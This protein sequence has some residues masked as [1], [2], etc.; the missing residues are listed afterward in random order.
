ML[1]LGGPKDISAAWR[2]PM[3]RRQFITFFG[4]AVALWPLPTRAQVQPSNEAIWQQFTEWLPGA[5]PVDGPTELFNQYRSRLIANGASAAEAD[6]QLAIIRRLHRE[7]PDAWRVM[8]NNI[9]PF[10]RSRRCNIMSEIEGGTDATR[11]S[12]FGSD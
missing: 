2:A 11:T 12:H 1:A 6:H 7:R 9:G 10:R 8:F 3:R 4:C 5:P